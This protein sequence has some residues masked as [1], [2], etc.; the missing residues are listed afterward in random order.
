MRL[1]PAS[2][3]LALLATAVSIDA[4]HPRTP[5][6]LD[7]FAFSYAL[8]E[9]SGASAYEW[10]LYVDLT[11][12]N[13]TDATLED[14]RVLLY[15]GAGVSAELAITVPE[16]PPGTTSYTFD[17]NSLPSPYWCATLGDKPLAPPADGFSSGECAVVDGVD[18]PL[19]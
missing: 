3:V 19:P 8:V 4:S 7:D 15:A 16:V 11:L 10:H 6:E 2:I 17:R 12:T 18:A 13:P 14:A 5:A 1:L 9:G